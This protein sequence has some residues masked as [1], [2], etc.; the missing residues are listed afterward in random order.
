MRIAITGTPGV[1]KTTISKVLR[2]RLGIKVIDITE[3]VKKYKLYTEKD[4]D[5]DSYV[6]DF[7]KLEKFI[8]EIEEKEKTII[9][10]GHVS[11]LLNPDYII[12]L[13]CNPEIIKER[14]E[15]RGYKPKKVLENIQAEILDVCLCESKGKVYEIDTTNRDVENIVDEIIEAIKHK[16]ERKGVVDWTEKYF[17]YLTLEIK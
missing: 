14:L 9:L 3:A 7:E 4:E 5:M 2:D 16:K 11:H 6:I 13:R 1:G 12:V 17:D 8:D 15:K 10:D